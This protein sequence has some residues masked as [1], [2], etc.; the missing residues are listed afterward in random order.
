MA[1]RID[2][3]DLTVALSDHSS[4][5]VLDRET[6]AVVL[7]EW[8]RDPSEMPDDNDLGI[9]P[10]ADGGE[11]LESDRFIWIEPVPSYESFRWMERFADAVEDDRVREHLLDALDRPK[12][13]RRFR[14]ALPDTVRDAW[15]RYE[16]EQLR[17]S[18]VDWLRALEIEAELVDRYG[19]QQPADPQP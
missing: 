17:E 1:I 5:W 7:A 18:A 4:E 13:F 10:G 16:E 12:P 8:L 15:Y 6:G 3:G 9:D 14:D 11:L 19:P 2:L